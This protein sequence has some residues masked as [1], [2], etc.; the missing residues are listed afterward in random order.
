MCL[1]A[2][3]RM[4]VKPGERGWEKARRQDSP[5]VSVLGAGTDDCP[6][7][8]PPPGC[9]GDSSSIPVSPNI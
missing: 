8:S 5:E 6:F 1:R 4:E 9:I 7:G 2:A 3:H